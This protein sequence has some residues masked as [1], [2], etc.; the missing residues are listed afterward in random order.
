MKK[1]GKIAMLMLVSIVSFLIMSLSF[2]LMF[3]ILDAET[4]GFMKV[5]PG[6]M[7]WVFLL[8]GSVSHIVMAVMRKQLSDRSR[9]KRSNQQRLIGVISFFRNK[10]AIVADIVFVLSL[11][12]F[13]VSYVLTGGTGTLCFVLLPVVVFAFCM[14]CTLNGKNFNFLINK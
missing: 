9:M 8:I 3:I 12:G 5:L 2:V 10:P 4:A 11:V 6:L 7:F 14:H 13:I 1:Q